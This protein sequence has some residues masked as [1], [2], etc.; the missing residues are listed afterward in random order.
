M[1]A[2][3][4]TKTKEELLME[5]RESRRLRE[6]PVG[7]RRTRRRAIYITLSE[8]VPTALGIALLARIGLSYVFELVVIMFS[9][10]VITFL[11]ALQFF[12]GYSIID[13]VFLHLRRVGILH[14]SRKKVR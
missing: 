2:D 5:L 14:Q 3:D 9:V 11:L 13:H 7:P 10:F 4:S 12:T 8:L 6:I 1:G